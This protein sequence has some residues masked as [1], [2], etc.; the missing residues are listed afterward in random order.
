MYEKNLFLLLSLAV[1]TLCYA[2]N[3]T[4]PPTK[5]VIIKGTLKPA[6]TDS[7]KDPSNNS[8]THK[9]T[10]TPSTATC[11][12]INKPALPVGGTIEVNEVPA[13]TIDQGTFISIDAP[14]LNL[15]APYTGYFV[16]YTYSVSPVNLFDR[17]HTIVVN[18]T[19]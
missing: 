9:F 17:V 12:T 18:E 14:L 7:H 19:E 11:L 10:C 13:G 2:T 5:E 6:D 1:V 15:A 4:N 16:S 8:V 3:P